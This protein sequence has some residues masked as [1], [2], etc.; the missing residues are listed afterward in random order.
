ML[1]EIGAPTAVI[2]ES[3]H[4]RQGVLI[5]A[6]TPEGGLQSPNRQ[7]RPRWDAVTLLDGGEECRVRLLE[8]TPT[9]HNGRAAALGEKLIQR[10]TEASLAPVG[11]NGC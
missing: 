6:L 7:E 11:R 8:C 1:S 9:R 5:A 2:R 4:S 10:Q 3:S